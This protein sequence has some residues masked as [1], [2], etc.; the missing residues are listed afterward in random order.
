MMIRPSTN[1]KQQDTISVHVRDS[2]LG[3]DVTIVSPANNNDNSLQVLREWCAENRD[4]IC[5]R[6]LF[7]PGGLLL[8]GW[9]ISQVE[10]AEQVIFDCLGLSHM[11]LYPEIFIKFNVRAQR[12]GVAPGGLTQTKLSRDAPKASHG[13]MQCPHVEF[14]L[15]PFRPRIVSFFVQIPPSVG[16]T[17]GRVFFPQAIPQLSPKLYDMLQHNGWWNPIAKVIQPSILVHPET[18]LET[19]QLYTFSRQLAPVAH[20]AYVS[21]R[22]T[23]RPDL[24][25]VLD[26]PY[27]GDSDF[28]IT[29][30]RPDGT[31]FE[32]PHDMQLELF[33]AIFSTI[34]LQSWQKG[35]LFLFDNILYGHFRMPGEQPRKLHAM[36][37]HEIDTR[38][39]YQQDKAPECVKKGAQQR[40]KGS[41]DT[42]L[43]QLGAG[44]NMWILWFVML[45]PDKL[46]Q[47]LGRWAWVD[48]GGWASVTTKIEQEQ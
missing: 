39:L 48:G 6:F 35:D 36:F 47:W 11:E 3:D 46:F 22:E 38:K 15:G 21:V 10:E 5:Q 40:A 29:L 4:T 42:T 16:G 1:I 43:H 33:K 41:I 2:G 13:T 45:L 44:G 27:N 37:A 18:G 24:P 26:I 14:G 28:G 31:K 34:R 30:V 25:E 7:Q 9:N 23:E 8:R 12:L 19:L 20:Q 32:M 17:T